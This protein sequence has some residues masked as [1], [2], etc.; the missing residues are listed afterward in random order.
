MLTF[1]F[2]S[3]NNGF[4]S[5]PVHGFYLVSY[6]I[7]SADATEY[8]LATLVDGRIA[9]TAGGSD[10]FSQLATSTVVLEL[11]PEQGGLTLAGGEGANAVDLSADDGGGEIPL[12]MTA[13]LTITL[14]E[15]LP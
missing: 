9:D 8:H 14:L 11:N 4:V 1:F 3:F 10:G 13:F 2:D 15:E 12:P 6:G 5:I 7:A